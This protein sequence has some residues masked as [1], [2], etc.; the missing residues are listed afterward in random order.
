MSQLCFFFFFNFVTKSLEIVL[1]Q[2][3]QGMSQASSP[4][5]KVYINCDVSSSTKIP[6]VALIELEKYGKLQAPN[7]VINGSLMFLSS[8]YVPLIKV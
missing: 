4:Q 1:F 7:H 5:R 3:N 8:N 2:N 6:A